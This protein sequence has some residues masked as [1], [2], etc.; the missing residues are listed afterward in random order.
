MKDLLIVIW[1]DK[2][3]WCMAIIFMYFSYPLIKT[4]VLTMIGG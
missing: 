2:F 4:V 1:N 3:I